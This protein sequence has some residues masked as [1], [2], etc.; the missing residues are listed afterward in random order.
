L[1]AQ[2]LAELGVGCDILS[3]ST[4]LLSSGER[5]L[6]QVVAAAVTPASLVA[7]DEPTCGLDPERARRLGGIL[8]RL[9]ETVPLVIAT[10]DDGLLD[11][12]GA[13]GIRLGEEP[14]NGK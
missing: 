12:I 10:Q 7:V 2:L 13:R 6:V 5:R 4:W 14:R 1:G 3:R 8:A 11:S 9:A